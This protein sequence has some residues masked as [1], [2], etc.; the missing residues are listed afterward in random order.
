MFAACFCN[1]FHLY[2]SAPFL[3]FASFNHIERLQSICLRQ[4][5]ASSSSA[6]YSSSS[7]ILPSFRL[8]KLT[9]WND[10][11]PSGE[12]TRA[13]R[14]TFSPKSSI[15]SISPP[16][17]PGYA[18]FTRTY[19]STVNFSF[20]QCQRIT[21]SSIKYDGRAASFFETTSL[22]KE[23]IFML[24]SSEFSSPQSRCKRSLKREAR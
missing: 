16:H 15:R 13:T 20:V 3:L 19:S 24:S 10:E 4:S 7:L 21:A 9:K 18:Q 8:M 23:W 6:Q 5:G 11:L 17:C 14:I 12:K 22:K 2:L 1:S